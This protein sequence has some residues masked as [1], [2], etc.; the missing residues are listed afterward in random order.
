M[1]ADPDQIASYEA[2]GVDVCV[3]PLETLSREKSLKA[4]AIMA[5]SAELS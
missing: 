2:I 3:F 5:R 4:V 1:A